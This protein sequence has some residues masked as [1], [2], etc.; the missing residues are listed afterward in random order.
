MNE[1]SIQLHCTD[2]FY[3]RS[4]AIKPLYNDALDV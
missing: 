1:N 4:F 3:K 2:F